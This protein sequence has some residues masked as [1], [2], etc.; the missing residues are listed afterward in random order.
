MTTDFRFA[1]E[2]LT[3]PDALAL[4]WRALEGET[5]F[6]LTWDWIGLWLEM[7]PQALRPML[8]RATRG[9]A[10]AGLACLIPRTARRRLLAHR[11]LYL[12]AT[13][14]PTLDCLT[15]EHNGWLCAAAD[16]PALTA[17]LGAWFA[18]LPAGADEL[19]L[20]GIEAPVAAAALSLASLSDALVPKPAFAVDLDKVRA[21]GG[22]LGSLISRNARQQMRRALRLF[23]ER[24]GARL[25]AAHGTAEALDFFAALKALHIASWERRDRRHAFAEP[26]F[27]RFHRALI[28]R[29]FDGGSVELLRIAVGDDPIGYLYNFRTG[30]RVYTYQ[31]GFVAGDGRARPGAVSHW[32]A[33]HAAAARGERIYDFMAGDNRLK[34]SLATDHYMLWWQTIRQDRLKYRIEDGAR[35]ARLWLRKRTR[36]ERPDAA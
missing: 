3:S 6:F 13:G 9:G 30:G 36:G 24:G 18:D 35:A 8:L 2:P 1:L 22:D 16:R 25:E 17:A 26:F 27:E 19:Y 28:E 14:D 29:S 33:I 34:R 15:V 21:A 32:L 31:S 10:T 12:H 23:D 4:E 7:L 20:P 5:S 11:G